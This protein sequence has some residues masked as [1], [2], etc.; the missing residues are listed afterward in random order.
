MEIRMSNENQTPQP[1]Q[2]G[3]SRDDWQQK[4]LDHGF[5]YWRAPDAH[6]VTGTVTQA[7]ELLQDLL[8]VEVEIKDAPTAP[9][10]ASTECCVDDE[11]RI[12]RPDLLADPLWQWRCIAKEA[13]IV[14]NWKGKFLMLSEEMCVRLGS[15][16]EAAFP[17]DAAPAPAEPKGEQQDDY[18]AKGTIEHLDLDNHRLRR[19]M[20]KIMARLAELLDEDQFANIESIVKEA[21]VEPPV[22]QVEASRQR[23]AAAQTVR[24]CEISDIQCSRGCG[25]GDC[26]REREA[27]Y[28]VEQ[29]AA[30]RDERGAFLTYW[31]EDVP[32]YMRE[33]WKENVAES[34]DGGNATDKLQAAHDAWMARAAASQA[35]TAAARDVP[36]YIITSI[37]NRTVPFTYQAFAQ[38]LLTWLAEHPAA[39]I[40]RIDRDAAKGEERP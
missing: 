37:F 38:N 3:A 26:K 36:A 2:A 29:P 7:V 25:V 32:E 19:A 24:V 11:G 8:G 34:L 18:E 31:C 40:E 15:A 21:G 27:R 22:G 4:A 30:A 35:Q 16:L 13:E 10:V 1:P 14:V 28:P 6:G 33:K 20:Q 39:E 9:A 12:P 23:P 5:Q 17:E